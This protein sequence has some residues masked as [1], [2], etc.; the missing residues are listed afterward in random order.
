MPPGGLRCGAWELPGKCLFPL[1][2]IPPPSQCPFV[3]EG[4]TLGTSF[5]LRQNF[6]GSPALQGVTEGKVE[7]SDKATRASWTASCVSWQA[8][9]IGEGFWEGHCWLSHPERNPPP[10]NFKSRCVLTEGKP[11]TQASGTCDRGT[12]A[13]GAALCLSREGWPYG[14][15]T[16][17]HSQQKPQKK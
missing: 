9:P 11:L 10:P 15:A 16:W 6:K 5:A 2:P 3:A 7:R 13:C 14:E 4:L 17:T 1:G 12:V 8:G